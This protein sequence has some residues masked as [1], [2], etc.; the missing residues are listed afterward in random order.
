VAADQRVAWDTL[1]DYERLNQF[2]PDIERSRVISRDGNRL[3]VEH[4]GAFHLL[5][6]SMPVRLRLAVD[7]EPYHRVVAH[8]EPGRVGTEEQTLASV[9]S[10]YR[11][12][13]LAPPQA[14]VRVEYE[15]RIQLGNRL[16]ELFNSMFG[17]AIVEHGLRRQ[18]EAMLNE[19]GRRQA[20][21]TSGPE[22][23]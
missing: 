23:R 6:M 12:V 7:Q 1:T 14:G 17:R 9:A 19:I 3:V 20:V 16:P 15:A 10:S 18:F 22:H 8:T 4:V 2:V 11:L 21:L 5:F 13:P